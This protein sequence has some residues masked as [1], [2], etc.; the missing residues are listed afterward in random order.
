MNG[1]RIYSVLMACMVSL[2][3]MHVSKAENGQLLF[4]A[5]MNTNNEV[6]P[7]RGDATG[8]MTFLLSEDLKSLQVHGAFSNLTGS[9]L[10]CNLHVGSFDVAGP[11]F[12]DLS[13]YVQGKRIKADLATPSR[14][15]ELA[16]LGEL[17]VN[18]K[19]SG[20]PNGE[21]RGQLYWRAEYVYPVALTGGSQIPPN[22]SSGFGLGTLRFSPNLT[23]MSYK[24]LLDRLSGPVK[25]AHIHAGS[26][27]SSGP[28]LA[29][30]G[31][32]NFLDGEITDPNLVQDVFFNMIDSGAYINVHTDSFPDGEIRGQILLGTV[33]SNDALLNGNQEVPPVTT[34]ARG[35]AYSFLNFPKMDSLS[36]FVLYEGLDPV[37]AHIHLGAAGQKGPVLAEMTKPSLLDG[38]YSGIVPLQ[39]DHVKAYLKD[40]LYFNIHTTAFPDGEIRGQFQNNLMKAFAFDLCGD[41]EVPKKTLPAN[42]A[43][44][45]AINKANTELEYSLYTTDVNG[46]AVSTHIRD[47]AFGSNGPILIPLNLPNPYA[48][49]VVNISSATASKIDND[50]AYINVFTAANPS[51]ELRGQI[52]RGLSCKINTGIIEFTKT[53]VQTLSNP[54]T[55]DLFIEA[56]CEGSNTIVLRITD[57]QG[58]VMIENAYHLNQGT[59]K[60]HLDVHT[61]APGIYFLQVSSNPSDAF[62]SLKWIK[63]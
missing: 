1:N 19:T 13:A 20:F 21:I 45:I 2:C 63:L 48:T 30:L 62:Q 23:R 46:D 59:S 41:Q 4:V 34:S 8:L 54:V 29:D 26:E 11:E 7:V 18:I 44:H 35:L 40:E 12:L 56:N 55:D 39:P 36:Y 61:F 53:Y 28:V 32:G 33:F 49:G 43:A 27:F 57:L 31:T 38:V 5:E 22:A 50:N 24:V 52:R 60:L 3:F 9:I 25:A 15:I 6:P 17:Y 16:T 37:S 51:G 42:G 10:A 47:A 58:N 14:F